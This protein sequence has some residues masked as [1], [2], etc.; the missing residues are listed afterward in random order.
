MCIRDSL[1][2][3][4]WIQEK[5]AELEA[6]GVVV[7]IFEPKHILPL[8]E[9]LR[10]CFPGD[11]QRYLRESMVRVTLGD[12]DRG[13]I[14]VAMQGDECVGFCQHDNERLGPFGVDG[15]ERGRG[16]GAVLLLR[17]LHGM[18]AKGLHNAWFISTT[19][20]AAKVY[21]HG[22]FKETRRYAVMKREL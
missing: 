4:D 10:K 18:K 13:G 22:G 16:V 6:E 2:T 14:Y 8:L 21:M 7:D 15:K 5:E 3:P 17:C 1:K 11:W 12:F 20:D 9:H 19:D